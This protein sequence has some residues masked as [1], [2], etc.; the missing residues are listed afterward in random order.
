MAFEAFTVKARSEHLLP[1]LHLRHHSPTSLDESAVFAHGAG[2]EP[3]AK[4]LRE[5]R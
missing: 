1:A 4:V 3:R 2:R 5:Q